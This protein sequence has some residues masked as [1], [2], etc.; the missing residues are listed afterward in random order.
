[1]YSCVTNKNINLEK[2]IMTTR[3]FK[4]T[5]SVLAFQRALIVTDCLIYNISSDNKKTPLFVTEIHA[6]G[7]QNVNKKE[8]KNVAN[9]VYSDTAKTS[10]DT[11]HVAFEFAIKFADIKNSLHSVA[12]GKD[13]KKDEV[14][15][16]KESVTSFIERV[17]DSQGLL[18]VANRFARNIVNARWLWRNRLYASGII[19]TVDFID[20]N[21][22]PTKLS[23]NSLDVSIKNFDAYTSDE[24]QLGK[25]IYHSLLG[26]HNITV[27]V[28]S[29]VDFG[30]KGVFEVFPSQL[31]IDKG[32]D[33]T[34]K[35]KFLYAIATNSPKDLVTTGQAAIR[36]Q[37]VT[38]AL[39]TID[40]WYTDFDE[41]KEP[42]PVEPVGANMTHMTFFRRDAGSAFE[43]I[44]H[45]N[46]VDVDSPEGMF[47]IASLMRGGV[48]SSSD[49]G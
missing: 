10:P 4:R 40:T 46:T 3:T 18:E 7:T 24:L 26:T 12:S 2:I 35:G 41:I 31:F 5:P 30:V 33:K 20:E 13:D 37:K 27:N 45:L 25:A 32:T 47:M 16:F 15:A 39:R 43:I 14:D 9:I 42:I 48:Y 19:T 36:D 34:A 49:K 1:M 17:N 29:Q 11:T 44:K 6:I 28:S 38:N 22:K 8:D 23:F 21:G